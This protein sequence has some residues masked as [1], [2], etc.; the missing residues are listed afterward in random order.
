MTKARWTIY[1][2]KDKKSATAW[3]DKQNRKDSRF[4]WVVYK[5]DKGGY[6]SYEVPRR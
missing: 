2:F 6:E 1:I 3:A 5:H 4:K